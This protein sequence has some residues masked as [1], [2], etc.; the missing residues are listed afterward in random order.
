M[1]KALRGRA[2][3]HLQRFERKPLQQDR[4]RTSEVALFR[5]RGLGPA[6]ARR[7]KILQRVRASGEPRLGPRH[8]V[9]KCGALPA[10][11]NPAREQRS[12][13]EGRLLSVSRGR[14]LTCSS[15]QSVLLYRG[16]TRPTGRSCT[17]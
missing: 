17:N 9:L 6:V 14:A 8:C 10:H 2:G 13:A 15:R 11:V 12:E 4:R 7:F 1:G 3:A 16:S 5:L